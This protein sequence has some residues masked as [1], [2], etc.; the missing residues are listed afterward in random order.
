[1]ENKL[2]KT[3]H[4]S[5]LIPTKNR[6]HLVGYA[7][8]SVLEQSFED[9]E[10]IIVDNDDETDTRAVVEQFS[11][12]RIKYFKTGGLS[13]PDNWEFGLDKASGRYVTVLEDKQ[14]Y[15]PNALEKINSA[16]DKYKT[17]V[18]VWEWDEFDDIKGKAF[19]SIRSKKPK[20]VDPHEILD[21]Y[22]REHMKAW[23]FLPRMINSCAS[24]SLIKQIKSNNKVSKFFDELSPDVC[25]AV[26]LLTFAEQITL[27]NDAIGLLGYTHQ[28]NAIKYSVEGKLTAEYY[29][30]ANIVSESVK[31]VPIKSTR[32]VHN[33]VYNDYLRIRSAVGLR[34]QDYVMSPKTYAGLCVMNLSLNLSRGVLT[35]D[36]KKVNNYIKLNGLS[37]IP[38]ILFFIKNSCHRFASKLPFRVHTNKKVWKARTILDAVQKYVL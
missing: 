12:S 21:I 15:Y 5:V 22:T 28:S 36:I 14:A 2:R 24:L 29:G 35:D 16:I 17:D 27:L 3:P 1:L 23:R 33:T 31:Y 20:V 7:I 19:R 25:A 8:Q 34:L 10:I 37:R 30:K 32:L 13:M 4:F 11:D 6:A 26:Y 9:F 38:F 18:L